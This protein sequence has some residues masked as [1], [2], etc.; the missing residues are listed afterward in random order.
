MTNIVVSSS[1]GDNFIVKDVTG[2]KS[3]G[4]TLTIT[5]LGPTVDRIALNSDI[6]IA[7]VEDDDLRY[8]T[9]RVGQLAPQR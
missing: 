9:S 1:V 5:S 8:Y 4:E 6:Y 7:R 2:I 3:D